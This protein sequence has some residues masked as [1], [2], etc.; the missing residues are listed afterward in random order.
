MKSY[1]IQAWLAIGAAAALALWMW[2]CGTLSEV[3]VEP[4]SQAA[5]SG[6]IPN[7]RTD[8][9]P[10]TDDGQWFFLS[11]DD[12]AY[13]SAG[14]DNPEAAH[15]TR[16]AER[17]G[18]YIQGYNRY[19][20]A[21]IDRVQS[22]APDGG[23]YFIGIKAVPTESPIGYALSLFGRPLIDPPRTTS[24]C[25]GSTYSAFIEAV[26]MIFGP[27]G[28][29]RLDEAHYEAARMQEPDGGRREDGVKYWGHWNDDGFGSHFALVQYSG[30][31]R[32]ITPAQARPGDFMNVSWKK[33]GGHSVVF[34]G[35]YKDDADGKGRL[36]YWSSQKSTNGLSDQLVSLERIREV[37]IVR[38]TTPENLFTFDIAQPVQRKIPGDAVNWETA[39]SASS[40]AIGGQ[41]Q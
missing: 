39:P 5:A 14:G 9:Q 7:P 34:L 40:P 6:P 19:V 1:R 18:K 36:L 2:G 10:T 24:Y 17:F 33:G 3:S 8:L 16:H 25:S 37:K 23:G 35:W 12:V 4:P 20:L 41:S 13:L 32:E 31:G 11:K 29:A 26:D 38:L 21:G 30:M 27:Q 28:A 22:T 15:H